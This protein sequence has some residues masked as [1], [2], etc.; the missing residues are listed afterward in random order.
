MYAKLD[1]FVERENEYFI[2]MLSDLNPRIYRI[3]TDS[4]VW[5]DKSFILNAQVPMPNAHI[6]IYQNGVNVYETDTDGEG[7]FTAPVNLVDN[8]NEIVVDYS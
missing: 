8:E 3:S 5:I 6:V 2:T 1:T 4:F 7:K